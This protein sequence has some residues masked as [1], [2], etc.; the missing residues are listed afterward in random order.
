MNN[1]P[2]N[3]IPTQ[4]ADTQPSLQSIPPVPPMPSAAA[5]GTEDPGKT[6]GII[7]IVLVVFFSIAGIVLS[8]VSMVKSKKAGFTGTLGL[9]GLIV[10]IVMTL[11]GG[12]ILTAIIFTA[13]S[14]I[15]QRAQEV[16]E[17]TANNQS[18]SRSTSPQSSDTTVADHTIAA[19]EAQRLNNLGTVADAT[20]QADII[21]YISLLTVAKRS[22]DVTSKDVTAIRST[23][24]D[25][26]TAT[27][28]WD[29]IDGS[30][31]KT[32]TYNVYIVASAGGGTD[33]S[34]TE[35]K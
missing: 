29:I 7:G 32:T 8:A 10:N 17:Q 21:N 3:P 24:V 25:T 15:Q 20:L 30:T 35:K 27:E 12:L 23:R 34:V 16:A 31:G 18:S 13:Y 33:F 2:L 9:V 22:S 11:L 5:P 26:S 14:G 1:D 4:A 28:E 6:L 19:T